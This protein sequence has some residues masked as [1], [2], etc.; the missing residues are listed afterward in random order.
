ME[1]DEAER[2]ARSSS[3]EERARAARVLAAGQESSTLVDELLFDE[4]LVVCKAA[5]EGL[6]ARADEQAVRR[7]TSAYARADDQLGHHFGHVLLDFA[8]NDPGIVSILERLSVNDDL[9]ARE[10]L[11]WLAEGWSVFT[12]SPPPPSLLEAVRRRA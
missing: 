8:R 3:W 9:G 6:L 2:A 7:F 1:P 11:S 12:G 5:A 4:D 10:A